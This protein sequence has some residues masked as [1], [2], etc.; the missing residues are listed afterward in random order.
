[1]KHKQSQLQEHCNANGLKRNYSR[2]LVQEQVEKTT[3]S[4]NSS[5]ENIKF[6]H[7]SSNDKAQ[8]ARYK[9]ILGENAP[10]TLDEFCKIKYADSVE[11]NELTTL[12]R[13]K[14]YLQN[15]LDYVLDTGEKSFIPTHAK[16]NSSPKTIAGKGAKAEI[17]VVD[18]LVKKYGGNKENWQKKVVNIKSDKYIFDVHWYEYNG[19]QYE[20]KLKHRKERKI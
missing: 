7:I 1:M 13:S 2:E 8:Y 11:W 5:L 14:N 16:F 15:R 6:D 12:V 20:M 17:R 10:K 3:F 19:L 18:T 9:N 4:K